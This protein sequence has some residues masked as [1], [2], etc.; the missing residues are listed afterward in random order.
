MEIR[1]NVVKETFV[2]HLFN[3]SS[4]LGKLVLVEA[5]SKDAAKLKID[6]EK[7]EIV[8]IWRKIEQEDEHERS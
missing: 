3:E 1:R 7:W 2:M 4:G 8:K 5:E 6:R